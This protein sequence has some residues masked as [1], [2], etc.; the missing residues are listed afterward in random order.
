MSFE[1][2]WPTCGGKQYRGYN[3]CFC[4]FSLSFVLTDTLGPGFSEVVNAKGCSS[5]KFKALISASEIKFPEKHNFCG[6]TFMT[7]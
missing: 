3:Y 2:S 6:I 7:S 4:L 1:I 5:A